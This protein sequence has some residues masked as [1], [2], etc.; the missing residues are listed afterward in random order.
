MADNENVKRERWKPDGHK[1][2]MSGTPDGWP[3]AIPGMHIA[4]ARLQHCPVCMEWHHMGQTPSKCLDDLG[5]L[6]EHGIDLKHKRIIY[7]VR[8]MAAQGKPLEEG[9]LRSIL[10]LRREG[11]SVRQIAAAVCVNKATVTRYLLRLKRQAK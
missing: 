2:E 6:I 11:L 8:M 3:R 10:S 1:W 7:G 5:R 4:Q 9:V